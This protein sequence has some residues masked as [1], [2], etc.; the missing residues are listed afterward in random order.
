MIR[1]DISFVDG[2]EVNAYSPTNMTLTVQQNQSPLSGAFV[3]GSGGTGF[4][5]ARGYSYQFKTNVPASNLIAQIAIPYDPSVLQN[6]S[7]VADN[8]FVGQLATD[9][10]AWQVVNA[11]RT[12]QT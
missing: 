1:N 8:T 9:S 2:L 10:K 5:L 3:T 12:V 6:R 4:R 7:L 11:D